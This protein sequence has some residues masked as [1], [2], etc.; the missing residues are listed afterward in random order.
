MR[1]NIRY[2]SINP[3]KERTHA[4]VRANFISCLKLT[5][6]GLQF[7]LDFMQSRSLFATLY[8]AYLPLFNGFCIIN[9]TTQ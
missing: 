3:A 9:F 2:K 7:A 5:L 1:K 4:R 8:A 6:D